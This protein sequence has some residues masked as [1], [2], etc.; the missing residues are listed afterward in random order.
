VAFAAA[1]SDVTGLTMYKLVGL[2]VSAL[3]ALAAFF[4]FSP[5]PMPAFEPTGVKPQRLLV[6]GLAQA[7]PRLLAAG[8]QGH[9]LGSD[10]Q[11]G[12]WTEATIATPRG[13]TLTALHFVDE[14]IGVAVGHDGWILRTTDGGR[15][16]D[17]VAFNVERSEPLLGVAGGVG[18]PMVAVGAFG[19]L[20]QS[21]DQGKTW[22]ER[23]IAPAGERHLNAVATAA[24]GRLLIGGEAG[25]LLRSADGGT[26]WE[27]LPEIYNGSFFG[28]ASLTPEDWIVWGMRG[29]VFRT[30]DF[31]R[32]WERVEVPV[33]T[34]LFGGTVMPHG[35]IV[36]VGE[37]G[38]VLVSDGP[39]APFRGLR[40]GGRLS[41]D[42]AWATAE[43]V[44]Y[45]AGEPGLR[46]ESLNTAAIQ[47][48]V[49]KN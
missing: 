47:G 48:T 6:N 36:L 18:V 10:D 17:E 22:R 33:E 2:A 4:A 34:A 49:P 15:R 5:R 44:L 14:S 31:G 26:T 46:A 32:T 3:V 20:V 16:W 27:R 1:G 38:V 9:I 40:A 19:R 30:R 42:S 23:D 41:L 39:G 11:G 7:G 29:R 8:E 37:G 24:G 28:V 13:S 21:D 12:N 45:V 43:D 25:T 35:Q